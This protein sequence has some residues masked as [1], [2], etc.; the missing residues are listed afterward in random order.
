MRLPRAVRRP[1]GRRTVPLPALRANDAGSRGVAF[2]LFAKNAKFGAVFML[3]M[4]EFKLENSLRCDFEE[5]KS[6]GRMI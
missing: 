1:A 2:T 3:E 4:M 5:I 6:F